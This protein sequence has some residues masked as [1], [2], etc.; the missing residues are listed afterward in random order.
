LIFLTKVKVKKLAQVDDKTI[1]Q[2]I[3]YLEEGKVNK[4]TI[5]RKLSAV[6]S[7]WRYLVKQ[8]EVETDFFQFVESPKISQKLPE[9]LEHDE[10]VELFKLMDQNSSFLLRDVAVVELLYSTGLRVAE[11]VSLNVNSID[12]EGSEIRVIGKREKERIVIINRSAKNAVNNYVANERTNQKKPRTERAL[13]LNNRGS[14][15]TVRSIQRLFT[16]LGKLSNR[17]L[18]PHVLR[19]SF[20]TALL[21]GGADLRVVQ[22]LL[23]HSSLSTT[24]LYTHVTLK[25]LKS[26]MDGVK[27]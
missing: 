20:A 17:D 24:Q 14:R 26:I 7:W 22:E 9:F 1:K 27:M 8:G 18:T 25:K 2:F 5:S 13:F 11:L 19:H 4:K 10:V 12:Y 15:L 6:K 3:Y 21:N 16:K 23:G